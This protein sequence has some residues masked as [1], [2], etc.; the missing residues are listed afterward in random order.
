MTSRIQKANGT[1]QNHFENTSIFLKFQNIWRGRHVALNI[2]KEELS[3]ALI[4]DDQVVVEGYL[5]KVLN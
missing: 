5:K 2:A 1:D 4:K 3:K